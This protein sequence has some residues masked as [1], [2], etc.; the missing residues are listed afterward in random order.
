MNISLSQVYKCIKRL[1]RTDNCI[2][3]IPPVV[4]KVNETDL[5]NN[6]PYRIFN[7][8]FKLAMS[9]QG[10]MKKYCD[11]KTKVIIFTKFEI[12]ITD[13]YYKIFW[14]DNLIK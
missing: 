7:K 2:E 8:Y 4:Y 3:K 11:E 5:L 14:S 9:S 10:F 12:I 6:G 13:E 1:I